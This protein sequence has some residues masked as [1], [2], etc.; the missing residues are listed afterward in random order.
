VIFH[1]EAVN[2]AGVI[3]TGQLEASTSPEAIRALRQRNLLVTEV[4][5]VPADLRPSAGK[6]ASQ[7]DLFVSL[8]EMVTLLESGVSIGET[9]ES[10]SLAHYPDDLAAS[11]KVMAAEIRKG[12][13]FSE[14]LKLSGLKLPDYV[15]YL[16]E[17]GEMTG[18]LASSL[19]EGVEQFEYD[20]QVA[21]EFKTALTYPAVLVLAGFG[22]VLMVFTFVVPRFIPMLARAD[23]LPWL[24]ELVFGAGLLFNDYYYIFF[25][26]IGLLVLAI[27]GAL[28]NATMRQRFYDGMARMPV[29]GAWIAETDTASWSSLMAALLVSKADLLKALELSSRAVKTSRRRARLAM[30]VQDIKAGET[31]ADSLEKAGVLTATG[32]NLIRS[33]EKTGKLPVMMKSVA[34]LYHEGA[35]NRMQ[36]VLALIE[37]LAILLI[38]G[39]IGAIILGVILAITSINNVNI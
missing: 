25:A 20:Q 39:L 24:S 14:A 2:G 18:Q 4:V 30:V 5:Q 15:F 38:G 26:V 9:I 1:Y 29:L 31:L 10:Q 17:A 3:V 6:R 21:R 27:V 32:Y 23:E 11:Y 13:S 12:N 37:P 16:A 22:A 28:G 19:R 34:K 35:K 36:R 7:Q 33:G 8:H